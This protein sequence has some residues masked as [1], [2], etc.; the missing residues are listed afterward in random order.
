MVNLLL[1]WCLL[2]LSCGLLVRQCNWC[3]RHPGSAI[4][5][6]DVLR[7]VFLL[8]TELGRASTDPLVYASTI[9]VA[10]LHWGTFN[11]G[12]PG[13]CYGEEFGEVMISRLGSMNDM[14]T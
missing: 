10:L 11:R 8:L 4:D 2:V 3:G 5:A 14:H 1:N 9:S 13:L 12:L 7:L 6:K